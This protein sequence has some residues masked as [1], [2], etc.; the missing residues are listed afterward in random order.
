MLDELGIASAASWY[1]DGFSERSGIQVSAKITDGI[2]RLPRPAELV[3]FRVLQESLTNVHR[4]AKSTKADVALYVADGS[5]VLHVRDYGTGIPLEKLN[6]FNSNGA[7]VGVGLTGM[8]ERV[9]EHGGKFEIHSS[10]TGTTVRVTIPLE[11][12]QTPRPNATV[13]SETA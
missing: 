2:G 12:R 9:R 5:A 1:L 11:D 13:A 4:H 10:E 6:N 8:R 7:H 3:L